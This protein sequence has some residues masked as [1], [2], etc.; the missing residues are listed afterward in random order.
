MYIRTAID[1][2]AEQMYIKFS[3]GVCDRYVNTIN[4]EEKHR[5][6]YSFFPISRTLKF[7]K[8]ILHILMRCQNNLNIKTQ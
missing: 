5:K 4:I 1:I 6:I 2:Y 7:I 3:K 8:H